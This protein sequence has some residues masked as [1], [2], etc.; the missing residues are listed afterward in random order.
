MKE[1]RIGNNGFSSF[2][3]AFAFAEKAAAPGEEVTFLLSGRMERKEPIVIRNSPLFDGRTI[4]FRGENN[5]VITGGVRVTGFEKV[6]DNLY[7]ASLPGVENTRN[8]YLD[9]K[10]AKRTATEPITASA[11]DHAVGNCEFYKE[12]DEITGLVTTERSLLS[13]KNITDVD[14]I[15]NVGWTHHVIPIE[16]VKELADGRVFI[17]PKKI[18]F[19]ISRQERG[20]RIGGC[21]TCFENVFEL[22]SKPGEWYF[23]RYEKAL[24]LSLAPGDCP[25]NHVVEVPASES[26][27][28]VQG[29]IGSKLGGLRFENITFSSTGFLRPAEYG[30]SD[31][32]A[33]FARDGSDADMPKKEKP[34]EIDTL[35][36]PGAVRILAAENAVF[37]NCTFTCLDTTA[38]SFEFGASGCRAVSCSFYE[39]GATALMMGDVMAIRA[40]HPDDPRETVSGCALE[41]STVKDTGK[42]FFSTAAVLLGYVSHCSVLHN[43]IHDVP[44]TGVSVGWGWGLS[45]VSVGPYRPTPWN[46]P[47]VSEAND[48][49][50]NHIYRCM[51]TLYDGGAIYTLGAME[52]TVITGN[53]IHNSGGYDGPGCPSLATVGCDVAGLGYPDGKQYAGKAPFPGGIYL[54]EGS[55][56]IRVS[57]NVLFGMATP[58]FYHS[59]IND[60][61]H[62]VS[63]E[64]NTINLRP[65]EKDFPEETVL[66][67]GRMNR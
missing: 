43:D 26:L 53:Y 23:D 49:S 56:G 66:L 47:S 52:G 42:D 19:D 9:G 12:G 29:E 60:G 11:W 10:F 33:G 39:L 3:E 44:Y 21:P 24:Y 62:R 51:M 27:L 18:P 7:R 41:N 2:E 55:R 36:L 54:D 16:A 37:E 20:V 38:L 34:F 35:K 1:I 28:L 64:N 22:L 6:G 8:L 32:Q 4:L 46:T 17:Q 48:I 57:G 59:Q 61:I 15:F 25:E 14:M 40:H 63:F 58:L 45:D 50:Y 5:A 65:G 30:H 13:W 67:A 31:L